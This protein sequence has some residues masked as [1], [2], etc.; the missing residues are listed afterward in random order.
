MSQNLF[1]KVILFMNV[2]LDV[3]LKEFDKDDDD[4]DGYD[5]IWQMSH[6]VDRSVAILYHDDQL[7]LEYLM[8][9]HCHQRSLT[10]LTLSW[11]L[12]PVMLMT[13]QLMFSSKYI[14]VIFVQPVTAWSEPQCLFVLIQWELAWWRKKVRSLWI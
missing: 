6:S 12:S 7:Q 3:L 9:E 11:T 4:D 1:L 5:T 8:W 14:Q 13:L 10:T 2:I